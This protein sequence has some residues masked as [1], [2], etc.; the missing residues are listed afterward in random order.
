M[1]LPQSLLQSTEKCHSTQA[2]HKN[3]KAAKADS[4]L[5]TFE[6]VDVLISREAAKYVDRGQ[7]CCCC[8]VVTRQ[9]DFAFHLRAICELPGKL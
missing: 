4:L 1:I 2:I 7:V 8:F 9:N 3:F 6:C 5:L